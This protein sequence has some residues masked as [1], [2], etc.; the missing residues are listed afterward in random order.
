M[1][2]RIANVF[3]F[4][5]FGLLAMIL[6]VGAAAIHDFNGQGSQVF[7]REWKRYAHYQAPNDLVGY[8][9]EYTVCGKVVERNFEA[10][11]KSNGVL[12]ATTPNYGRVELLNHF[13]GRVFHPIPK[14]EALRTGL[15]DRKD[16]ENKFEYGTGTRRICRIDMGGIGK[17]SAL[18]IQ[19][20][21]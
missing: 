18:L 17:A 8:E 20:L 7:V 9:L 12:E 10:I 16:F 14:E 15:V 2:N 1:L 13:P 3:T 19:S 21:I 6:W 4:L 5:T 11:L